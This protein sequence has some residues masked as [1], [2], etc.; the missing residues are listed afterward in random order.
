ME[1][2]VWVVHT[3]EGCTLN[4]KR[5]R[6]REREKEVGFSFNKDRPQI[7][8]SEIISHNKK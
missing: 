4:W 5:E 1:V 6:K 7:V 8:M 2:K 3:A